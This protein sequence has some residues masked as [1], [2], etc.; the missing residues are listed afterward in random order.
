MVCLRQDPL[1]PYPKDRMH[2]AW[3]S[4]RGVQGSAKP[5]TSRHRKDPWLPERVRVPRLAHRDFLTVCPLRARRSLCPRCR[6]PPTRIWLRCVRRFRQ[7]ASAVSPK[8]CS[9]QST[10]ERSRTWRCTPASRKNPCDVLFIHEPRATV[11]PGFGS[12]LLERNTRD[13]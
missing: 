3:M 5:V 1:S 6:L 10:S 11:P 12:L 9:K 7:T 8:G 13:D 4:V 2:P